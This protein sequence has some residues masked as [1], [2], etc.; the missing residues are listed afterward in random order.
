MKRMISAALFCAAASVM[1]A[2]NLNPTISVESQFQGKVAEFQK[3]DMPMDVPDSLLEFDHKFD[4]SVFDN[5]FKGAYE[6]KPYFIEV[7]PVAEKAE[8]RQL[9]LNLG[10]GY[11]FNPQLNVV[12][13]PRLKSQNFKMSIYEDFSAYMGY[14]KYALSDGKYAGADGTNRL[15]VQASYAFKA[16]DLLV[17]AGYGII[18]T[19][20]TQK[21]IEKMTPPTSKGDGAALL[22][23]L[24]AKASLRGRGANNFGVDASFKSGWLNHFE[25][26]SG[27]LRENRV[28]FGMFGGIRINDNSMVRLASDATVAFVAGGTVPDFALR[29]SAGNAY[30][31]AQYVG[32]FGR[33]KVSAGLKAGKDFSIENFESDGNT[34]WEF[35]PIV[36]ASYN[37]FPGALELFADMSGKSSLMTYQTFYGLNH[38][39]HAPMSAPVYFF[40]KDKLVSNMGVKGNLFGH[41]SYSLTAGY[42]VKD[43]GVI[44]Y[45]KRISEDAFERRVEFDDFNTFHSALNLGW[46]SDA[47]SANA[48]V[49]YTDFYPGTANDAYVAPADFTY[50]AGVSYSWYGR[51]KAGLTVNGASRRCNND[52]YVIPSYVNL[53]A[54]A[55]YAYSRKLDFWLKGSNLLNQRILGAFWCEPG[56]I[57]TL[58]LTLSL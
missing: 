11:A 39:F 32:D 51:I 45:A 16:A 34:G 57:I 30:L 21:E 5:P 47:F 15:G 8:S 43:K 19:D 29:K 10:L 50:N 9:Y 49:T 27:I 13:T 26:A 6:F 40:S 42:D 4:Y 31:S 41:L 55:S 44:V 33:G 56:T 52:G 7:V 23:T 17:D 14:Y 25:E 28:T 20:F 3:M 35:F 24:D 18:G 38:F 1:N 48:G 46:Q 58:G 2:Q 22:Q 36:S 53:G 54:T 37:L 12:W